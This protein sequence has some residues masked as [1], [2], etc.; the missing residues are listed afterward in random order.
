MNLKLYYKGKLL[1]IAKY[2]RDFTKKL[3]IGSSKYL[4][5]Q[6]LDTKFPSKHLFLKKK[7]D[8]FYMNLRS[9]MNVAFQQNGQTMDSAALKSKNLLTGNELQLANEMTGSVQVNPDWVINYEFVEPYATVYT[10]KE[11]QIIS[12]YSRRA[13]LLPFQKFTRNFLLLALAVTVVGLIVF[14]LVKPHN[15]R[16]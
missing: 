16:I 2:G 5:W 8:K 3:Y 7:D 12:Q 11:K 4:F 10:E 13:E 1:D 14:D 9:G 6:I 15:Q